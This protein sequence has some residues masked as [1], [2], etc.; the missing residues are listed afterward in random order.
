M[1]AQWTPPPAGR[2]IR[3]R[4][5][6]TE[7]VELALTPLPDPAPAAVTC[8]PPPAGTAA[9]LVA[10]ALD[11]L[12]RAALRLFPACRRPGNWRARPGRACR[13]AGAGRRAGRAQPPLRA[14][15]G[16]A[17]AAPDRPGINAVLRFTN[18]QVRTELGQVLAH[19]E[20]YLR[21]RRTDAHKE[22][23]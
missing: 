15:P 23:R 7:A 16:R 21:S 11:E 20:R 12:E 22:K 4:G 1:T 9:A 19:L 6:S 2:V 8:Y 17:G 3:L 18:D 5:A 13:R 10:A 14:V